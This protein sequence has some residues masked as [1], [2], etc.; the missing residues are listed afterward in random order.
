A[1][2]T[3]RSWLTPATTLTRWWRARTDTDP[4]SEL[5]AL[6]DAV[7]TGHGIDLYRRIQRTTGTQD[8]AASQRLG[9]MP[10]SSRRNAVRL[11]LPLAEEQHGKLA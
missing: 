6:I 1:L 11:H 8:Q 9:D 2:R 5:Q 3:I 4:P 7:T 10:M